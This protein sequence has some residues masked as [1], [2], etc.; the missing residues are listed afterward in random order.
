[1]HRFVWDL[2]YALPKE[3]VQ[4]GSWRGNS[5][6]WAPPG[7]YTV[8]LTADGKALAQSLLVVKDPRLGP[9]V[10]DADL[11]RQLDATREIEA[12]RVR[13][14]LALREAKA[15][16]GQ[17]A[18][19]R[20]EMGRP[21]SVSG[22][23]DAFTK[24]LDAAAG[25]PLPSEDYWDIDEIPQNTLRRVASSLAHLVSAVQSAD[26]A[27]TPDALTGLSARKEL[28]SDALGRWRGVVADDLPKL[29]ASLKQAGLPPLKPESP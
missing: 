8:R 13:A 20:A 26:A 24:A 6:P 29:N 28:L 12:E 2:R 15:L 3:L 1:M 22:A 25:P 21:P 9:S 7:R 14:T 27:P 4:P 17:I 18:A 19:L 11:V 23:L 16:R 10:T 5:G